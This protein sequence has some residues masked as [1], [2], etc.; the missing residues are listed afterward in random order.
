MSLALTLLQNDVA[1]ANERM[2]SW[3]VL[4]LA[5]LVLMVGGLLIG[6]L[7][8]LRRQRKNARGISQSKQGENE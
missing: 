8:E 2:P 5:V 6:I 7:A 4:V 3:M 1:P